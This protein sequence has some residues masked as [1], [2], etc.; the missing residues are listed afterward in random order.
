MLGSLFA[1]GRNPRFD[2]LAYLHVLASST[3]KANPLDLFGS[4]AM[5]RLLHAEPSSWDLP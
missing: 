4:R 1:N 3:T 2:I 5:A